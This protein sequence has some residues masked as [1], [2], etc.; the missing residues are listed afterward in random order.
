MFPIQEV[1]IKLNIL[2]VETLFKSCAN[3]CWERKGRKGRVRSERCMYIL[4][5]RSVRDGNVH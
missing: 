5:G 4:I 3:V 1:H 2:Q